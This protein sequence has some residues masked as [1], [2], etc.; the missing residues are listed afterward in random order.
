MITFGG[1]EVQEAKVKALKKIFVP[2]D[3]LRLKAFMELANY[4]Q[5]FVR[6]FS[7]M[8]KALT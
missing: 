5:R 3:V 2:R 4:Y 1:L 7:L 8:S 6:G